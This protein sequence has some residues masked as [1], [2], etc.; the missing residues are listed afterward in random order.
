MRCK[1][2]MDIIM[3]KYYGSSWNW[4]KFSRGI[5]LFCE[6]LADRI[7]NFILTFESNINKKSISRGFSRNNYLKKV[8]NH[9][10]L[11][12]LNVKRKKPFFFIH[13]EFF[14]KNN[15][16]HNNATNN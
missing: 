7:I 12:I 15:F 11:I 8:S 9:L 16:F 14:L 6:I 13:H 5:N 1:L 10:M 3:D 2:I 4:K